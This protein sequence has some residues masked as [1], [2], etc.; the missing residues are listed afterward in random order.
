MEACWI[1]GRHEG[2]QGLRRWA[3]MLGFGGHFL[4]KSRYYSVTFRVLREART[5]WQR[6]LTA[7]PEQSKPLEQPTVLVVNFLVRRR[8]LA[9]RR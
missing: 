7:G 6:T 8:R 1:L 3:H 5:V 9:Q 2:W 4:T